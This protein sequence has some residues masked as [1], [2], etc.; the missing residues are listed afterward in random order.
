MKLCLAMTVNKSQG[1]TLGIV[2]LDLSTSA[3]IHGRF[4]VA[5]SRVPD[6]TKLAVL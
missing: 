1:Q 4:Y 3:F 2:G 6:V 5:M